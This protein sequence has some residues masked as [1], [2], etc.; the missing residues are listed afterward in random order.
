MTL[1]VAAQGPA[2]WRIR[3]DGGAAVAAASSSPTLAIAPTEKGFRLTGGPGVIFDPKNTVKPIY[4]VRATF[5]QLKAP[6]KKTYYGLFFGGND[7]EGATRRMRLLRDRAGRLVPDPPPRG[8]QDRRDGHVASLR[9]Q[10]AR[11]E[12][13][14]GEHPRSAGRTD[15]RLLPGQ[16][17]RSSTPRRRVP[18]SR[19]IHLPWQRRSAASSASG[20]TTR[21]TCRSTGS[22]SSRRS[23]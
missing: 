22:S 12:R 18:P 5:T 9:D 23:V 2:G 16:R 11:C 15:R 17:R 14:G 19:G 10:E 21:S 8:R 20:A 13:Q 1:P 4:R 7:M 3:P 6:A